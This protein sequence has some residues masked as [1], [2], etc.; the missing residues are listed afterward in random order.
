LEK[1]LALFSFG[2]EG[3][4]DELAGGT[5]LTVRLAAATLPFGLAL[6]LLVAFARRSKW[7][8]LR[9]ASNTF[10][11]V[12][13]GLPEL[14]TIF[15]VY[16]GGQILLQQLVSTV[17][18]TQVTLS[19]FVAGMVALGLVFSAYASEV[20]VGAFKN[21]PQ[22]HYDAAYALGMRRIPTLY[23]VVLPQFVRL[24]L[25]GVANLWLILLKD[26]ALVSVIALSD[27]MRQTYVAV[28]ATKQPFA[29]YLAACLIYLT[30][31]IVSS[32]GITAIERWS[33]R[34]DRH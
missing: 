19:S 16:Y 34:G 21:I 18:D 22:G 27:L 8:A 32:F 4:G 13:R 2:P 7:K 24:A 3:W 25:P 14:L 20:F 6:G 28:G 15:I 26:T 5:W 23:L 17:S 29:F 10:T 30:M 33:E 9:I 31:S 11:T 12:F 1:T